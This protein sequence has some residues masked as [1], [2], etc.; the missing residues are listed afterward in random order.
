[1]ARRILTG[2]N[3]GQIAL[4]MIFIV[5]VALILYAMSMNISK[6]S[7]TKLLLTVAGNTTASA[8]ASRFASYGESVMQTT[9]GG[10]REN[11]AWTGVLTAV[12]ALIIII[13]IIIIAIVCHQYFCISVALKVWVVMAVMV[14]LAVAAVVIQ[15][16]YIQP[17]ITSMWNKMQAQIQSQEDM[18]LETALQS[19]MQGAI[20]DQASIRDF[21]DYNMDGRL[22]K[23]R[24][25]F[26]TSN[27]NTWPTVPRFTY[28]YTQRLMTYTNVAASAAQGFINNAGTMLLELGMDYQKACCSTLNAE[29]EFCDPCC[30]TKEVR[31]KSCHPDIEKKADFPDVPTQ[32]S[33]RPLPGYPL[34]YDNLFCNR[35]IA[36]S[37]TAQTKAEYLP[38]LLGQDDGNAYLKKVA[39][40]FQSPAAVQVPDI[41]GTNFY[42][43]RGEDSEGYLFPLLWQV[44]DGVVGIKDL[45]AAAVTDAT[46]NCHWCAAGNGVPACLSTDIKASYR[47]WRYPLSK[48]AYGQLSLPLPCSGDGCC[49]N[50]FVADPLLYATTVATDPRQIDRVGGFPKTIAGTPYVNGLVDEQNTTDCPA[51]VSDAYWRAGSDL[52]CSTI[53]PYYVGDPKG[54]ACLKFSAACL[55]AGSG[56]PGADCTCP[57]SP[58]K[59]V[60]FDDP[61]DD[62][63]NWMKEASADANA[64]VKQSPDSLARTVNDWMGPAMDFLKTLD[65]CPDCT[66]YDD[67]ALGEYLC[68]TPAPASCSG[69]YYK[70]L[71]DWRAIFSTWLNTPSYLSLNDNNPL[72]QL[73][74]LPA[75]SNLLP[76]NERNYITANGVAY[77]RVQSILNCL[78]YNSD[79]SRKFQTCLDF[80][81]SNGLTGSCANLPRSLL[82]SQGDT[83]GP[84]R[85]LYDLNAMTQAG[86]GN[87]C[88]NTPVV[89]GYGVTLTFR[90]I[91]NYSL[92]LSYNQD[93]KMKKRWEY[94]Y[95]IYE[96]ARVLDD[97]LL[98]ASQAITSA[99]VQSLKNDICKVKMTHEEGHIENMMYYGWC[100]EPDAN[101][102]K[103]QT[104]GRWHM[105]KSEAWLPTRC[106]GYGGCCTNMLPWVKTEK[107]GS[108]K[109]CYFMQEH[110][111]RVKVRILR[112]DA[113]K[114]NTAGVPSKEGTVEFNTYSA[115]KLPLWQF[116]NSPYSVENVDLST[117]QVDTGLYQSIA[118]GAFIINN[119][120][121]LKTRDLLQADP[122]RK[123]SDRLKAALVQA[124]GNETCAY[125]YL[126]GD[127]YKIRF[128]Q[129]GNDGIYA[130]GCAYDPNAR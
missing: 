58:N 117:C 95:N 99:K 8:L 98:K 77:G 61:F 103:C 6:L 50:R 54:A 36:V 33:P 89:P 101:D 109:R 84:N 118:P 111:G 106:G 108:F 83:T 4:V 2:N 66:C 11:C 32:C 48:K 18:F 12:I 44:R 114:K 100:T 39:S 75:N 56:G 74:C 43:F 40:D 16:T 105:V 68:T 125:Y 62:F 23:P 28:Y 34:S 22:A 1:M 31:P 29:P 113:V 47:Y 19:G 88:G 57:N 70:R 20:S 104:S 72:E 119:I 126:Q 55:S 71:Q 30:V 90:E 13:I 9:L 128:G 41:D 127:E 5:A 87:V 59:N 123:C 110:S 73:W 10:E 45:T 122:A 85:A 97:R 7:Q 64:L 78:N 60:W 49:A 42:I 82:L 27:P 53:A 94:L 17:K 130:G 51:D 25:P 116:R 91:I 107:E 102:P 63:V 124:V 67:L 92:R 121:D 35:A 26:D 81:D 80:C 129:C 24:G 96:M 69:G 86:G 3:R 15:A 79:N 112:Y 46:R 37:G 14:V 120:Q 115:N 93:E 38:G 52:Y 76:A 65:G 21:S